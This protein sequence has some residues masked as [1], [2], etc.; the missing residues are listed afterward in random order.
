MAS[1]T[2]P[3]A[4]I[5][6]MRKN[7]DRKI[8]Q[9]P[10]I[11][12]QGETSNNHSLKDVIIMASILE[13]EASTTESRGTISGI[14][15]KRLDLGMPLQ[16]DSTFFY[17]N[18][19]NTYELTVK[20]LKINSPYNTYLHTGLPPTP[21]D[22][23]GTDS[24]MAALSPISTNYLYYLSSKDGTI[25]YAKTLDEHRLNIARYLNK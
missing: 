1:S 18:G 20:D 25:H 8:S 15:W 7:F 11:S 16:V 10:Q 24:I 17:I 5:S 2:K 14:L 4:I 6:I 19:K 23:S 13:L 21:V 3:E 12:A 9:I 22:N